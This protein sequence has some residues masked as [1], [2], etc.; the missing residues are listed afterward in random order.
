[1]TW[2]KRALPAVA[3]LGLLASPSI[4][5]ITGR[6]FEVSAGGGTTDDYTTV[7]NNII[8]NVNGRGIYEFPSTG[9]HNVYNNNVVYNNAP[10]LELI[11]GTQA[12]TLSLTS[13]QFSA[14]F[15]NYTGDMTGDYHLR[16]GA[17]AID[18]GTL[19]CA[20]GVTNCV[21]LLDWDGVAR[22]VG[23]AYDIGAYEY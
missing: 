19:S 20:A 14:L 4:A 18:A 9:C 8:V 6:P 1:M 10:N 22:P 15:V 21:P 12:G 16:G 2:L 17:V 23:T 3:L 11:C 7:D 13:T 5:Q